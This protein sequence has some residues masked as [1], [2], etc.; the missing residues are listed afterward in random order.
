MD[1]IQPIITEPQLRLL[2][3][4]QEIYYGKI[5]RFVIRDGD[6]V[7]EP[8]TRILRDVKLGA[9]LKKRP[10][11][12]DRNYR[13]KPQVVEMLQQL[14]KLSDGVVHS[15]EIHDGLPFRMQIIETVLA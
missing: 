15:L 7:I 6:P 11:L 8:S 1:Q 2:Q 3:L 14:R 10:I 13:D 9:D 12:I 5:E 4:I